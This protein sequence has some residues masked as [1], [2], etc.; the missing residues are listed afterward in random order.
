MLFRIN[1]SDIARLSTFEISR[2]DGEAGGAALGCGVMNK[3]PSSSLSD[4]A[5]ACVPP[6]SCC[7][8]V[9]KNPSSS[10]VGKASNTD[11]TKCWCPLSSRPR[12]TYVH[13]RSSKASSEPSVPRFL[14]WFFSL[15]SNTSR[16]ASS[17][18]LVEGFWLE[19]KRLTQSCNSFSVSFSH[20]SSKAF[21]AAWRRVSCSATV[22]AR[23]NRILGKK[24]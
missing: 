2:G 17:E 23:A 15:S 9:G 3:L 8:L 5:P 10:L 12:E 14:W 16:Y 24:L 13:L 11:F 20:A 6:T 21:R 18:F 1:A 7:E 19:C 22:R 4:A